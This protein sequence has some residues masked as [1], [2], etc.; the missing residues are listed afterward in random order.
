[1][2]C[3][4]ARSW[5]LSAVTPGLQSLGRLSAQ[6]WV[7]IWAKGLEASGCGGCCL[8]CSQ[9]SCECSAG[10]HSKRAGL[11]LVFPKVALHL[12]QPW[13]AVF[14]PSL[15]FWFLSLERTYQ[16]W[17]FCDLPAHLAS[18]LNGTLIL[19]QPGM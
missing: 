18:P 14:D 2:L 13:R 19:P 1:M 8:A 17:P 16:D 3:S 11:S 5:L 12:Q 15:L 7:W 4:L 9:L 10:S 6:G